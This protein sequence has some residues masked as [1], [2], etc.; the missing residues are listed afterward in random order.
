MA[1]KFILKSQNSKSNTNQVINAAKDAGINPYNGQ[2]INGQPINTLNVDYGPHIETTEAIYR[3]RKLNTIDGPKGNTHLY[4]YLIPPNTN[5]RL[6]SSSSSEVK[7]CNDSNG[8][9]AK[10]NIDDFLGT[11][12]SSNTTSPAGTPAYLGRTPPYTGPSE[13]PPHM[14]QSNTPLSNTPLSNK[15]LSNKPLSPAF[16]I[17]STDACF[18]LIP[19]VSR[20]IFRI[21]S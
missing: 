13:T 8:F 21:N 6:L 14:S 18:I 5:K 7:Y 15:P 11:F 19:G 20:G 10:V 17:K 9:D 1:T 2:P 4:K 3:K 12:L 16:V